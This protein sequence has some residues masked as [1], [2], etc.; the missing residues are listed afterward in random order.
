[1]M[2]YLNLNFHRNMMCKAGFSSWI[3]SAGGLNLEGHKQ[4]TMG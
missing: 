2:S 3:K 4:S 1:M